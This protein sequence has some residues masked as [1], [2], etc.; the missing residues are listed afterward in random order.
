MRNAT[1]RCFKHRQKMETR[2]SLTTKNRSKKEK[3][4]RRLA[5]ILEKWESLG[6]LIKQPTLLSKNLTLMTD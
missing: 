4:A 1:S 6:V 3:R 2:S 5:K